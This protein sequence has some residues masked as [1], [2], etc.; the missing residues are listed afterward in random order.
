[1]IIVS[2]DKH[3][4]INFDRINFIAYDWKTN[5]SYIININYGDYNFKI[6]GAYKTEERA[7]EVLQEIEEAL[8]VKEINGTS[9]EIELALKVKSMAVYQMPEE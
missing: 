8:S 9:T 1:M 3:V 4:M 7:K 2:Q 6:I 5:D